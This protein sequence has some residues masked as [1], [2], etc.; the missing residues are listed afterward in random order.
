MAQPVV[1]ALVCS[2]LV[3]IHF[4]RVYLYEFHMMFLSREIDIQLFQR[5]TKTN[6][7]SYRLRSTPEVFDFN[8]PSH[9]FIF[10]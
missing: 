1:V 7:Y 3:F 6:I 5:Y 2:T 10:P 8:V 9:P 4:D